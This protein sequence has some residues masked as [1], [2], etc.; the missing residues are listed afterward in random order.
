[1]QKE[2]MLKR[3]VEIGDQLD[4]TAKLL[5]ALEAELA[6]LIKGV[7]CECDL[8]YYGSH[9]WPCKAVKK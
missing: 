8:E 4:K 9:T 3:I 7:H 2:Q 1:M 5:F 6:S